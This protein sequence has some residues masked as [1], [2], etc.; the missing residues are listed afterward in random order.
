VFVV[1]QRFEIRV[2]TGSAAIIVT[3]GLS[4]LTLAALLVVMG[5]G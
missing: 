4:V 2:A 1:A 3:T 5:I